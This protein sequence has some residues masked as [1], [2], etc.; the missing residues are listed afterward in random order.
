MYFHIEGR[1]GRWVCWRTR[2]KARMP[3]LPSLPE[4]TAPDELW[5][6]VL[7]A[8]NKQNK[9]CKCCQRVF[10][11][12]YI[13]WFRFCH[14]CIITWLEDGKTC[15]G[16]NSTLGEVDHYCNSNGDTNEFLLSNIQ[17]YMMTKVFRLLIVTEFNKEREI[18]FWQRQNVFRGRFSQTRSP[19][20]RSCN[21]WSG[22]GV[23]SIVCTMF[24]SF[25]KH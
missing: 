16:D 24:C 21:C 7:F 14:S 25:F 18:F 11:R 12:W 6:Q 5:P 3:N 17:N 10:G 23:R 8:T 20:G 4:G 15:P 22:R 2:P 19:I 1:L 9:S 13:V